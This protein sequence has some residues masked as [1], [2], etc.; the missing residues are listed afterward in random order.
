[1]GRNVGHPEVNAPKTCNHP[2]WHGPI[3]CP[4]PMPVSL[5]TPP[6]QETE[7]TRLTRLTAAFAGAALVAAATAGAQEITI[8]LATPITSLDPHFH[9]LTPNNSLADHVFE[10]LVKQDEKQNMQPGLAESWKAL[11]DHDLGNQAAQGREV[12]QRPGLHRRRRHRDVQARAQRAEQPGLVRDLHAADRRDDGDRPADAAAEDRQAA[13]AAAERHGGHPASCRRR[14]PR[15][16][17]TEDFNSGKAMIGTGPYRFVEYVA[18]DRV[19]MTAQRRVLRPE[20]GLG[21]RALQDDHER[22]GARRRAARRRRADDRRGADGG[23][24]QAVQGRARDARLGRVEPHHLPAHGLGPR[25]ELALRDRPPT[26]SR[27]RPTR[28]AI[29]ACARRSRR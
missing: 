21:Q 22:A 26:A 5:R 24:R 8:A 4:N 27:W 29:R 13:S 7:M 18:G 17:K 19:V 28:C 2:G 12:P 20:A 1:M 15:R 6:T 25:E 3:L 9:N 14:S 23:H 16:A 10:T 11:N